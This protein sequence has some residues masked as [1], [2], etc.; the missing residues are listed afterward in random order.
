MGITSVAGIAELASGLAERAVDSYRARLAAQVQ[1]RRIDGLRGAVLAHASLAAVG[2]TVDV[3]A[4]QVRVGAVQR[5]LDEAIEA[6]DL[7]SAEVL[8]AQQVALLAEPSAGAR[9]LGTLAEYLPA[10]LADQRRPD[11][12]IPGDVVA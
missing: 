11:R 9:L 6:G 12:T 3:I 7:A 4:L 5:A 1:R 10:V 2:M 8:R